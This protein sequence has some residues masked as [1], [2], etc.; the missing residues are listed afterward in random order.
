M[1]CNP[2]ETVTNMDIVQQDDKH[3]VICLH[4]SN[5]ESIMVS[6][7]RKVRLMWT[8][9]INTYSQ[10]GLLMNVVHSYLC[11]REVLI[12]CSTSLFV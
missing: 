1:Q 10:S 12:V 7:M 4:F 2:E 3:L 9:L 5:L 11:E 6:A 8:N